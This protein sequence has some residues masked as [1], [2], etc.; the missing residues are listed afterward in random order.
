MPHWFPVL[1]GGEFHGLKVWKGQVNRGFRFRCW[2]VS[3]SFWGLKAALLLKVRISW[4]LE[5]WLKYRDFSG[6]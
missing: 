2:F 5:V 1:V 3:W 4:L 6:S